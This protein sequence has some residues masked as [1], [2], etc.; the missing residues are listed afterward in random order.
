MKNLLLVTILL[1][2]GCVTTQ[3]VKKSKTYDPKYMSVCGGLANLQSVWYDEVTSKKLIICTRGAS[4]LE[5]PSGEM[6][7]VPGT[8]PR[9]QQQQFQ[10]YNGH[11]NYKG[12]R[13]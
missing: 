3:Q 10:Q 6:S 13:I 7:I 2:V 5:E 12:H 11:I 8:E 9:Q 4:F 1:S